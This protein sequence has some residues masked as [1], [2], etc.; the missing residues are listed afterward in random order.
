MFDADA[1][2][3]LIDLLTDT[4]LAILAV[5]FQTLS[6]QTENENDSL[7]LQIGWQGVDLVSDDL[8][9]G[10]GTSSLWMDQTYQSA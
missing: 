1:I 4:E 5:F 8:A 7:I 3:K 10:I 9:L 6:Q 2:S